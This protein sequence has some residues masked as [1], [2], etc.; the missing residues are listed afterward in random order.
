MSSPQRS[1]VRRGSGPCN[2]A[3]EREVARA[4]LRA[5]ASRSLC[6]LLSDDILEVE[7]GEQVVL[8]QGAGQ[9]KRGLPEGGRASRP[10]CAPMPTATQATSH[11]RQSAEIVHRLNEAIR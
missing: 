4:V 2:T 6:V 3:A 9:G 11:R 8:S 1:V 7:V 10:R 5:V